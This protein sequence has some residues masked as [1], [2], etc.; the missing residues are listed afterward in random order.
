M[1]NVTLNFGSIKDTVL[2]HSSKAII[3]EGKSKTLLEML[4]SEVK[5]NPVLKL[6]YLIYKNIQKG[7]FSKEYLAER[8]LNQN[9]N[10]FSN[11]SWEDI[12]NS[13]K[14]MRFKILNNSH[15]ESNPE[16]ESL[17]ESVHLLIKAKTQKGF[18]SFDQEN[19]A[20]ENVISYLTRKDEKPELNENK[21][22]EVDYPKLLS[23]KY[24]T[25]LAVN[26][27]NE[28][29]GHLNEN[30]QELFKVLT[31][32]ESYKKNYFQDL[33]VENLGRIENILST[34]R[35]PEIE[36]DLHKFRKK[37]MSLDSESNI[38]DSII[39]LYEL[40]VNLD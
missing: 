26:S 37:I 29:Y 22:E 6:Q 21:Q 7:K 23:W 30:E 12:L 32:D 10:L 2:R 3:K 13:N 20:Y 19:Q 1:K 33:K 5:E 39:N 35:D 16:N 8:Y 15:V 38:D 27:F 36:S 34:N 40:K 9:L 28:R 25:Q 31:S 14:E 18:N 24:I 4:V 11:T 17:F